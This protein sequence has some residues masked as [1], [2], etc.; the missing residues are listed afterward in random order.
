MMVLN[1]FWRY[2]V[3]TFLFLLS[4]LSYLIGLSITFNPYLIPLWLLVAYLL[5]FLTVLVIYLIQL[6]L[7]LALPSTNMY[8]FYLMKSIAKLVNHFVIRLKVTVHGLEHI[9]KDGRLVIYANHKS[10]SDG[11]ALLEVFTR[12]MT[13]T[14]KKSVMKIPFVGLWLKSYDVFPI[15]RKNPRET[16]DSMEVAVEAVKKGLTIS[17]FPEGTIQYRHQE[18][19]TEMKS[20]AFKL[21]QKAESNIL[22]VRFD[23]N[24]LTKRRTPFRSTRRHLTIFPVVNYETIK[25]MSSHEIAKRV[26]DTINKKQLQF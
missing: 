20:G 15:N 4:F 23:G 14:P 18:E 13:F 10:Y 7:V 26:M 22:I 16:F 2:A 17:F 11:F 8:K 9:P 6:P 12:P 1:T 24:D 3:A 5:A 25:E 19:V 21:A